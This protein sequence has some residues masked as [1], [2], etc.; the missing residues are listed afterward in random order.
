M[1]LKDTLLAS[2]IAGVTTNILGNVINLSMYGNIQKLKNAYN[3]VRYFRYKSVEIS[4]IDIIG[5]GEVDDLRD[6]YYSINLIKAIINF[7]N[8]NNAIFTN[9]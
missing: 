7:L 9:S 4:C 5:H 6:F 8:K 1:S 3:N 2:A